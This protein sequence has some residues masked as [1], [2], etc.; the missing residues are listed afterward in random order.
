MTVGAI[1]GAGGNVISVE[2]DTPIRE[3]VEV[4]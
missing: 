1:V 2:C 3:A 4:K